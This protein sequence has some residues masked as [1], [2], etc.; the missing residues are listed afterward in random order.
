V[1]EKINNL[2]WNGTAKNLGSQPIQYITTKIPNSLNWVSSEGPQHANVRAHANTELG[3]RLHVN[4][5]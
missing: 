1:E 4:I 2:R 3:Y 5:V